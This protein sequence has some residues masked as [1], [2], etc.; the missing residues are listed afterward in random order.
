MKRVLVAGGAGYVGSHTVKALAEAG[1]DVTVY[2]NLSAGH[3]E[4]VERLAQAF[5]DRRIE[6]VEG[7]ILDTARVRQALEQSG[8]EAVMHFAA[9]LSVAGSVRDPLGY[10]RNNVQGTLSV[11]EAMA[12]AGVPCFVFSST[13]A[14]F[15]EPV[16]P[17]IDE[18]HPQRPINAYGESKLAVERALPHIE[19]A[20][21][22]RWVALRY[23]NASG[24]DPDG[25]IGE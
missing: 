11:L 7:D 5:P 16:T 2:D 15:G 19:R 3:R 18:T 24:A 21:G 8:A 10:Y 17:T 23:F 20:H 12:A 14:T 22:I 1:C 25:L 13:C 4:A 9:L 6:L